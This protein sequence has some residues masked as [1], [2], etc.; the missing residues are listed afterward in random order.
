M[1][2]HIF[3]VA[4]VFVCLCIADTDLI[5]STTSGSVQGFMKTRTCGNFLGIPYATPPVG[6]EA[7]LLGN[8]G[9]FS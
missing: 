2:Q 6:N 8:L 5:V 9:R 1:Q 7:T 3:V 4:L